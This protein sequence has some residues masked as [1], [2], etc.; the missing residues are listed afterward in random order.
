MTPAK[1]TAPAA[2]AGPTLAIKLS[3]LATLLDL[4][5]G[6]KVAAA[7][8]RR[9]QLVV[10]LDGVAWDGVRGWQP[11]RGATQPDQLTADYSVDV[12]GHRT[13]IALVVPEEGDSGGIVETPDPTEEKE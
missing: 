12:H 3:S 6:T 1:K 9:G 2:P 4:P 11:E 5:T 13:L 8:V 7:S 10:T